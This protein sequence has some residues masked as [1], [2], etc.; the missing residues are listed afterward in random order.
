[1]KKKR[2][3]NYVRQKILKRAVQRYR[4]RKMTN[5]GADKKISQF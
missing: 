4:P 1:M 2:K 3:A 5:L